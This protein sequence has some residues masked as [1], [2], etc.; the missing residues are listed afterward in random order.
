MAVRSLPGWITS[1]PSL[2]AP[3]EVDALDLRRLVILSASISVSLMAFV[4][5]AYLVPALSLPQAAAVAIAGSLIGA[6][7]LAAVAAVSARRGLG[8]VGLLSL[9]LGVP[10]GTTI[11][12][13]LFARHVLWT[14]FAIAFAA[15]VAQHVPG[16]PGGRM[17]WGLIIG[18]LALGLA[19]LPANVF[20]GRWL[21][22]FAFWVGAAMILLITIISAFSYGIPVLHDADGLGG[23]PGIGQGIDLV[24]AIPLLWLPVIA[25]YARRSRTPADAAAGVF[26]GAGVMTAWYA[27]AGMLWVFTVSAQDVAGFMIMLPIGAAGIV[28]VLA[29]EADAAAA[30]IYAA[31]MAGGRFGYRWFRPA[32]VAA[33]VLGAAAFSLADMFAVEDALQL[34]S[35]IFVP[36]FAVVL[37]RVFL[38]GAGNRLAALASWAVGVL[39]FGWINPGFWE[40]WRD[41]MHLIFATVLRA[42]FPLD[43]DVTVIP[44]T[45]VSFAAAAALYIALMFG[46]RRAGRG[47]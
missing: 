6:A 43:G 42:P 25:D 32:A 23:W 18:A 45:V 28:V 27:I 33:A 21:G 47:A 17:F 12:A 7:L 41:L 36:L 1:P 29:L 26:A 11:A 37:A 31:S 9:A 8:T 10:A 14:A 15:N 46:A 35:T 4:P 40:P 3:D 34:L 24:A 39:V 16:L 5:G 2:A 13:L 22:W 44:A 30:N 19:M 38:P 20:V